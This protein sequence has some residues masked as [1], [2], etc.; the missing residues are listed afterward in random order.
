MMNYKNDFPILS[1]KIHGK[2]LVYLDSS[3]SS[4]KPACVIDAITNYYKNDHANVHRGVYEL[5]QRAT[6]AYENTRQH[7]KEFINAAHTHEIIFTRGATE[8]INLVANCFGIKP[9]DEV[10][11]SAMEHH[12]NIVPWQLAGAVLKV[13]PISDAGELDL[14]QYKKLF[15]TKTKIV[16]VSHASN[17]LGTINP[18]KEIVEI[19]HQHQVP[20]L[21]DGAQAFPHLSVD[22][23]VLD[24]DFYVFSSHKAYGPTGV[25]VLYGKEK[26]LN[27]M[28]P[29]QGGG[30][31]IESVTFEKT[32]WNKLPFKFEAGTPN[33][34][35]VIGFD[36]A[37]YYLQNA[38]M[39]KI[40]QHEKKL[41]D[42]ATQQLSSIPE[43]KIIGAARNKL[44]VI[45]FV[46]NDIHPH[47]IGTILDHHGIAVRAGHHCAMPLMQR[48]NVPACVRV[49][50][51]VYNT[52]EDVDVLMKGLRVV[53]EMFSHV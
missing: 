40:V 9:A 4:Q 39:E 53:Q 28:P 3:A 5:S 8:G 38:G 30:D 47:D 41:L 52:I 51:G 44:G 49:S 19:A 24:V 33:I 32:T 27:Q 26:L 37:L 18:L 2:P 16:S 14:D 48:F 50:F 22:V 15:S 20:V 21:A 43:I 23:R 11:V 36:A 17:V 34:G 29:Y 1:Q 7:I 25:G 35:G 46:L 10:I 13:I 45:S 12:S 42:Y 6:R 31:M